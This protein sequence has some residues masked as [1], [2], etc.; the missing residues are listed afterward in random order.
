MRANCCV[1][2]LN[3]PGNV[4]ICYSL[5]TQ[6]LAIRLHAVARARAAHAAV[7]HVRVQHPNVIALT[8]AQ[9]PG[10][11]PIARAAL[12]FATRPDR[13]FRETVTAVAI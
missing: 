8:T 1:H 12:E 11:N 6:Q 5:P 2:Q 13:S 10:S 9:S 7:W 3:P 4:C